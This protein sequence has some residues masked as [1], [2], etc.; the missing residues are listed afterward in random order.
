MYQVVTPPD[1][2]VVEITKIYI[3][4]AISFANLF[5][6][7]ALIKKSAFLCWKML[8]ISDKYHPALCGNMVSVEKIIITCVKFWILAKN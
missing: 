6:C 3:N 8:E 5:I 2:Y 1:L 7:L 4:T